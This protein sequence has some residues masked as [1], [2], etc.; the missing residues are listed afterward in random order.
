MVYTHILFSSQILLH[1]ITIH[2][3]LISLLSFSLPYWK[4]NFVKASTL[5]RFGHNNCV[6][7][8]SLCCDKAPDKVTLRTQG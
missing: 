6:N 2:V 7:F 8:L 3:Y 1:R 5:P 4:V